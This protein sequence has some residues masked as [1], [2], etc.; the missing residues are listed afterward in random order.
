MGYALKLGGEALPLT[1]HLGPEALL[2]GPRNTIVFERDPAMKDAVFKLFS[3]NHSPESQASCLSALLCCLPAISAPELAYENVFRVLIVQFMDAANLDLRALKKSCV[4]FAQPDG[5]MIPFEA[6]N[7]FYRG[8]RL[9]KTQEIQ[10]ETA[11]LI[12][13]RRKVIPLVPDA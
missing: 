10:A 4:H 9:A 13:R 11:D 7:L 3:T 8:E 1:R 12:A 6:F 2:A 5:R